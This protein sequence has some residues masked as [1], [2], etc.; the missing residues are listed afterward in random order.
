M[1]NLVFVLFE[2]VLVDKNEKECYYFKINDNYI[3]TTVS[4]VILVAFIRDQEATIIIF[5][6]AESVIR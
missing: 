2:V 1:R 6:F 4:K 3:I 5:R